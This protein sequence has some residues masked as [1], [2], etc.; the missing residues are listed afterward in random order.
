[1]ISI[2]DRGGA[3]AFKSILLNMSIIYFA[4]R[5][6]LSLLLFSL[7]LSSVKLVMSPFFTYS[8]LPEDI[9]I[10]LL[11]AEQTDCSNIDDVNN[12]FD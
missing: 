5:S 1:M 8:F 4:S 6:F 3:G 11:E 9:D 7:L 10:D 12:K 2:G